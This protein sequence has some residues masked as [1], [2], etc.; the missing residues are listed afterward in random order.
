MAKRVRT[1]RGLEEN[2][3]EEIVWVFEQL[4]ESARGRPERMAWLD[5]L[6]VVA[7]DG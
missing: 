2:D 1:L 3:D 6:A 7:R 4:F 5:Q